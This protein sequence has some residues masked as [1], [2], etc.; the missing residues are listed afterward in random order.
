MLK[1]AMVDK[2]CLIHWF[3]RVLSGLG[4][5]VVA[6]ILSS[7]QAGDSLKY[8]VVADA[9]E[10]MSGG[11]FDSTDQPGLQV[12]SSNTELSEMAST[13]LEE[14]NGLSRFCADADLEQLYETDFE[15][16]FLV[17][18]WQGREPSLGYG[19][20]IVRVSRLKSGI[21]VTAEFNSPKPNMAYGATET[22]PYSVIRIS[23]DE[24]EHG[25]N[26]FVL[27]VGGKE[28]AS[29]EYDLP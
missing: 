3:R 1:R 15:Q 22:R 13:P 12:V 20:Q 25:D 17:I 28:L 23:R 19:V 26:R 5:T 10:C 24:I 27:D 14:M 4:C 6:A 2:S 8:S 18:V 21:H 16:D 29:I 11:R 9:R 7:C